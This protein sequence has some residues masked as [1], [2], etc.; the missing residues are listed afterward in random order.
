VSPVSVTAAAAAAG[1][2]VPLAAQSGRVLGQPHGERM[3][4]V[5]GSR[6]SALAT[7]PQ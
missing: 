6:A 7:S 5:F 3:C 4:Q 1:E 2:F